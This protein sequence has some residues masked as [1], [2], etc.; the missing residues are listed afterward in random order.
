MKTTY[1]IFFLV[2]WLVILIQT[3]VIAHFWPK[4]HEP[5]GI[6]LLEALNETIDLQERSIKL[7]NQETLEAFEKKCNK[8]KWGKEYLAK[9]K[10]MDSLVNYYL[11]TLDSLQ[12]VS[13]KNVRE[14][15]K[16]IDNYKRFF[17]GVMDESMLAN[18]D[19]LDADIIKVNLVDY[20]NIKPLCNFKVSDAILKWLVEQ[21]KTNVLNNN[22]MFIDI[23]FNKMNHGGL[24][25][26]KHIIATIPSASIIE[27]GNWFSTKIYSIKKYPKVSGITLL[28]GTQLKLDRSGAATYKCA[29]DKIGKQ[30]IKGYIVGKEHCLYH[31]I[32]FTIDYEVIEKCD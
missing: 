7:H 6:N 24:L 11:Q 18:L 19:K 13:A 26:D 14:T 16:E 32:P 22:K 20:K 28:D 3:A 21:E 4:I 10:F 15:A 31:D 1:R 23:L 5:I 9:A 8:L 27:K 30:S 29:T 17:Y 2:F 25:Y 12:N